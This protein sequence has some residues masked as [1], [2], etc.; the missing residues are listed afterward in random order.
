MSFI[1]TKL[2]FNKMHGDTKERLQNIK[3][4]KTQI[5]FH[6]LLSSKALKC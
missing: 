5:Q 1:S 4:V 6:D 3:C 2:V